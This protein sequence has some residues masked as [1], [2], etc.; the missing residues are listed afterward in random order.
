MPRI[1][2]P[3]TELKPHYEVIVVGSGYGG[4]IAANRMARCGRRVALLERGRELLPGD[5]PDT[6]EEAASELQVRGPLGIA[7]S[8]TG[9]LEFRVNDDISVFQGCGLGGTSLVNAGVA[10][11]PE[12]WVFDD[13]RWPAALRADLRK[14]VGEGFRLAREMLRPATY[15]QDALRPKAASLKASAA[16]LGGA[17]KRTP[18]NVNF[19]TGVNHVGVEQPACNDCGDCVSG[20]NTG[21]KNTLAMNYL[22]DAVRHG[23]QVFTQAAVR[24]L[25][26]GA[27]GRWQVHFQAL[28]TGREAFDAPL[29]TVSA[30]VVILSAGVLGTAGILMRS[31]ERGLA[32]SNQLGM[33]FSG[34]GDVL[35]LAYNCD[36][37][38][39]SVG[40]LRNTGP[41]HAPGPCITGV[42][43]LR[44]NAGE[45]GMVIEEGSIPSALATL[46]PAALQAA[47][48]AGHDTDDTFADELAENVRVLESATR[49]AYH[50]AVLHSQVYLVMSH[51]DA[52]GRLRLDDDGA[53]RIEWENVG[54]Q[55][56]FDTV[57][58]NL[59]S[60]TAAL[61]GT[62]IPN[63][64][65]ESLLGRTH[66]LVTVH[67]LG[68]CCMGES[69]VDGV[70]DHKGRVFTGAGGQ[71]HDGLYVTD[72]S[73]IPRPLGVNPLLTISALA[74]RTCALLAQD[75]GWR[76]DYAMPAV[77]PL[78]AKQ[79]TVGVQF[80]ETMRGHCSLRELQDFAHGEAAGKREGSTVE[81]TLTMLFPD[82]DAMLADPA[83]E[84]GVVG[85]VDAPALSPQP[86][87]VH[88]GRFRLLEQ[89]GTK[90]RRMVYRLPMHAA[91]GQAWFLDGYKD[92]RDDP[93]LDLWPD[94]TTLYTTLHKGPDGSGP[95]VGKGILRI[96]P[97]DFVRQLTTMKTPNASGVER[98]TTMARFGRFF[99]GELWD[100]FAPLTLA[101]PVLSGRRDAL[102]SSQPLRVKRPL[103]AP[104]PAI[105][106]FTTA[107]GTK[108]RLSRYHA[109]SRGPVVLVHGLGVSSEIFSTD[110]IDTNLVEYLCAHGYDVWNLDFR[111]SILLPSSN[112]QFDGDVIAAQD[113]PAAVAE[114]RRISGAESVQAVVHCF[115]ATA[116][117]MAMLG[118]M[119]GVRSFVSSQIATDYVGSLETRLKTGLYL[120]DVLQALGVESMTAYAGAH[121]DWQETL[122]DH[123]LRLYPLPFDEW[124]DRSVCR[125]IAFM[126][127]PLY[128]HRNLTP[129]THAAMHELFGV[130]N[131]R[132]FDHIA[133]IGRTGH[134][135]AFD[136]TECYMPYLE[137]LN[138]PI[139]F[140]HG[141]QNRCFS[142]VST[143]R[144]YDTLRGKF[145][146]HLYSRT[147]I[148]G[149]GHIDCIF[150]QRADQ[151]VF[152]H[153]VR[154]LDAHA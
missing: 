128:E 97:Q 121:P 142:P 122:L 20:C 23:A 124:C 138:L 90:A 76:I 21:A 12:A 29:L 65:W 18:I 43:D 38:V 6:L 145:G 101:R 2:S 96:Q 130:A 73:V 62:F 42:I 28:K 127:A 104:K 144:T 93:G 64:L 89:S 75:K 84:G 146:D 119:Q 70:V 41:T 140:I 78:P 34:N 86:L 117:F 68:G 27:D 30:D 46:L 105:H 11:E 5:F 132:C 80:T 56:V 107:D 125:R 133:R 150:G 92:I 111:A 131:L 8:R 54:A 152:P 33:R 95:V 118:G 83:H 16:M 109:G 3:L 136:G 147:V 88:E 55:P 123:A 102:R 15:P 129:A 115:G 19:H 154:H 14:G 151:D 110:T 74:E 63:P 82:L 1:S 79:A 67:P 52:G 113:L 103:R 59:R 126:Y 72:A 99:A 66:D 81:F 13:P 108:L 61:G 22:P 40:R 153:V 44:A 24:W 49:G 10:L 57:N 17:F 60:A 143:Q 47:A 7:G 91:D 48:V 50:G 94:T 100:V 139:A 149:Y 58:R 116:W 69:A 71:V 35:A 51:D 31:R 141:A 112:E 135:V 32:M 45:H 4:A 148:D 36:A 98:L 37:P 106:G 26:R 25:A 77:D 39:N 85:T 120:P 114:V 87:R 53:V 9:L 137:R 134:L